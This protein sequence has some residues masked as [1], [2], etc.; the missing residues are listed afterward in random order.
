MFHPRILSTVLTIAAVTGIT[1]TVGAI[2]QVS[3]AAETSEPQM[4][5]IAQSGSESS[6]RSDGSLSVTGISQVNAPADQAVI[7][8][9]YYPNSYYGDYSADSNAVPQSPQ[10]LPSDLKIVMDALTAAGVPASNVKAYPDFTSPG[11]MRVRLMLDQ[12]T[13]TRVEQIITDANTA[14][15]K[16]N[17]YTS[18]GAVVGYTVRDC[19]AIEAQ[20]RQTAMT[21][22]QNRA[23]ALAN[24]AG[25]QLGNIN[26]LSESVI[27]GNNYMTT[28][29]AS[30][31]PTV[32]ADAYSLPSYDPVAPAI[33]KIIYSLSATYDMQ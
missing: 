12:P 22:A 29:P 19:Q 4:P 7:V 14:V 18:S 2:P 11:S 1:G 6:E 15:T 31:D 3:Q 33:V 27:W 28:C 9:T 5:L 8:L 21:D 24:V 32:Y 23:T 30:T 25:Q 20:A 10:V 17:R 16:S 13:Q 26:F